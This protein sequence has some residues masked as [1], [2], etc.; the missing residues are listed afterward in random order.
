MRMAF[1]FAIAE[2]CRK[3]YKDEKPGR[4]ATLKAWR[5][6]ALTCTAE[7][8]LMETDEDVYICASNYREKVAV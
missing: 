5:H 2:A 6:M 4:D 1:V 3:D 8:R 7:Y